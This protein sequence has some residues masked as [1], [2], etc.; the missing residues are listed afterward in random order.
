MVGD[1]CIERAASKVL[2]TAATVEMHLVRR[3]TKRTTRQRRHTLELERWR[4]ARNMTKPA[5]RRPKNQLG[6]IGNII[7]DPKQGF[8]AMLPPPS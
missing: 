7:R 6:Y 2:A 4:N 5:R 8:R 3:D 1:T